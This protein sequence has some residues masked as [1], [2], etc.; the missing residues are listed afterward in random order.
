MFCINGPK[1]CLQ[2]AKNK[3][4]R[5]G[6]LFWCHK[7]RKFY[8]SLHL[9]DLTTW[10]IFYHRPPS[11]LTQNMAYIPNFSLGIQKN[12]ENRTLIIYLWRKSYFYNVH[13]SQFYVFVKQINL[14]TLHCVLK[15]RLFVSDRSQ[16]ILVD[17]QQKN[18]CI[19]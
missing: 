18:N 19:R 5:I 7:C 3:K 2:E 16:Q 1:V 9:Q 4:I 10:R 17:W 11:K 8:N 13:I 12:T 15:C 14:V 6:K